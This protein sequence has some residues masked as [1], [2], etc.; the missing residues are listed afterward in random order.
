MKFFLLSSAI[1]V[2]AAQA[3]RK[4]HRGGIVGGRGLEEF[5]GLSLS[6]SMPVEMAFVELDAA[7]GDDSEAK[8]T[9]SKSAKSG[10][11]AHRLELL[12]DALDASGYG[13]ELTDEEINEL[14]HYQPDG[15]LPSELP[16]GPN[17]GCP[18]GYFP[19]YPPGFQWS[20]GKLAF[21]DQLDNDAEDRAAY[22]ALEM[23][24]ECHVGFDDG[25]AAK[26]PH[27]EGDKKW[28]DYCK[29][30]GVWNGDF[31]LEDVSLTKEVEECGCYFIGHVQESIDECPGVNLGE[32]FCEDNPISYCD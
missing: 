10:V 12:K 19:G 29:A 2:V 13:T 9:S 20:Q 26:I 25:C 17:F 31:L 8:A 15:I 1:L 5:D 14:C 3:Q 18:L 24:C 21:W 32:F 23:Y 16:S 30:A 28:L 11:C 7:T 22:H 4:M 27:E 6:M